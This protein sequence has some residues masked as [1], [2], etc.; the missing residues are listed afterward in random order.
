M[1]VRDEEYPE[2]TENCVK[3]S[4]TKRQAFEVSAP[5]LNIRETLLRSALGSFIQEFFGEIDSDHLSGGR[6]DV[7]D[8]RRREGALRAR[9]RNSN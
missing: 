4:I 8:G 5:K 9:I 6:D 1:R 7:S 2:D 3:C